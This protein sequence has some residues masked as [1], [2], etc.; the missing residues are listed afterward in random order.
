MKVFIASDHAGFKLK[1][2]IKK[3]L[4]KEKI[5]FEDVGNFKYKKD[6]DYPDFIIPCVK[7]VVKEKGMGIVLGHSGQGEAIAANKVKEIRCCVYYGGDEKIIK[8]SRQHNAAN[9]LSLG[10]GFLSK[11]KAKKVVKIWLKT[12]FSNQKRHKRRL[13]KLE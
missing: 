6:D 13:R 11:V 7:K 2:E 4:E 10:A 9:V 5:E 1:E 3:F 8:L 12:K